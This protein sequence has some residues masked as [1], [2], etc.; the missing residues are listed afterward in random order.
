MKGKSTD[1]IFGHAKGSLRGIQKAV[2][3]MFLMRLTNISI[4][5][6]GLV[7]GLCPKNFTISSLKDESRVMVRFSRYISVQ[8]SLR[9]QA[10]EVQETLLVQSSGLVLG[11]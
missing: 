7:V 10:I 9:Y 6:N 11:L 3:H 5:G 8:P 2:S 4:G 1:N